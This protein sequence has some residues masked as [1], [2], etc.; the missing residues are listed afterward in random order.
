MLFPHLQVDS[1]SDRLYV[2][3]K[4]QR[5]TVWNLKN[6]QKTLDLDLFI[7]GKRQYR[8]TDQVDFSPDYQKLLFNNKSNGITVIWDLASGGATTVR[9]GKPVDMQ[10]AFFL[11]SGQ[12]F[13]KDNGLSYHLYDVG[14]EQ[15]TTYS[16]QKPIHFFGEV[17]SSLRFS[18]DIQQARSIPHSDQL[19]LVSDLSDI[20]VYDYLA[21]SVRLIAEGDEFL[22][23][24][25]ISPDGKF[26]V[27]SFLEIY[28]LEGTG[29]VKEIDTSKTGIKYASRISY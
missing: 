4:D 21:K 1:S 19:L 11:N 23:D 25:D 7:R 22:Y 15:R 24:Y 26:V 9:E 29:M 3:D 20:F 12:V 16:S 8:A 5:L 14:Q 17:S 13:I 10:A 18:L 27:H 2:I 6:V 28:S